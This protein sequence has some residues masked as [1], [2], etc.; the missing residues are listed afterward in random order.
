[1]PLGGR[2]PTMRERRVPTLADAQRHAWVRGII[3]GL[4]IW[5]PIIFLV[6]YWVKDL[7][8]S[9]PD[10]PFLSRQG[11]GLRGFIDSLVGGSTVLALLWQAM[12]PWQPRPLVPTAPLWGYL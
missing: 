10:D 2:I 12:P 4:L 5:L 11:K 8:L 9:L 6:L 7:Y 3:G 1:M